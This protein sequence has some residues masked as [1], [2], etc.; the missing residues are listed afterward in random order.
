M[1]SCDNPQIELNL[2]VKI[3]LCLIMAEV[4]FPDNQIIVSKTDTQSLITYCNQTFIDISGFN[5]QELLGQPHNIIR[6]PDMPM[7]VYKTLWQTISKQTEFFGLVKN[8][9]KNGDYYWAFANI[10]ASHDLNGRIIGYYSVRR[11]PTLSLINLLEP[12]YAEMLSIEK[13]HSN[14]EQA[15]NLSWDYLMN[16]IEG[17]GED[18]VATLL[19]FF[20]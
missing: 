6:H 11:K 14:K 5:E 2:K 12:I 3:A 20:K 8:R 17:L 4:A 7:S 16:E 9:C 18:Y 10:T 19:Q 15:M 1:P 13:Q